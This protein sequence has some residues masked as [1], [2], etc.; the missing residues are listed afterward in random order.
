[1]IAF[2]V[3]YPVHIECPNGAE[4]CCTP[5]SLIGISAIPYGS[6][7]EGAQELLCSPTRIERLPLSQYLP[8]HTLAPAILSGGRIDVG[9][10]LRVGEACEV[11]VPLYAPGLGLEVG[12]GG[13]DSHFCCLPM[14]TVSSV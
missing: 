5:S 11:G 13:L 12:Y 7:N 3:K 10:L 6:T 4:N 2:P 14:Y 9:E 8:R 1:M